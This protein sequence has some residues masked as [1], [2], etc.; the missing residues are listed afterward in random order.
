[1]NPNDATGFGRSSLSRCGYVVLRGCLDGEAL[2][3]L[4]TVSGEMSAAASGIL[5]EAQ[6]RGETAATHAALR[7]NEL[8]VVPESAD[9]GRVCRYEFMYGANPR[10]REFVDATLIPLVSGL[11][12]EQMVP[13]KDKTN[14]KS[15]GGGAFGPHQD[16]AA[17]R[18]FTPR[19][20]VTALISIDAAEIAN[21]CVQFADG[22]QRAA[23]LRPQYIDSYHRDKPLFATLA[24]GPAHGDIVSEVAGALTWVPVE[25]QCSDLVLFDSFVPHRSGA[26]AST[27]PRRA[28]FITLT[29]ALEGR[30]Y[31]AYYTEKRRNYHDPKFHVATPTWRLP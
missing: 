21:G 16:F 1:M 18:F 5:A 20:H 17:Y 4:Q 2:R 15:P 26:N 30:H 13:F 3:N 9:P 12:G 27:V 29:R 19:S 28:M 25:T 6:R 11:T 23:Q 22:Y 31:D 10:F 24:G 14:E 7:V 8:I